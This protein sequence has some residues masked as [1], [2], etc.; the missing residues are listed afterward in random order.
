MRLT[1]KDIEKVKLELE[2]RG[3]AFGEG[4]RER[5]KVARA[6]GDLS[7]NFEYTMAKKENNQNNGRLTYLENLLMSA[8]IID[9]KL[10][11]DEVGY[12]KKVT[13]YFGDDEEDT[14]TFILVTDYNT[15]SMKNRLSDS[16]PMGA[17]VLH[18]KVGEHITKNMDDGRVLDFTI[19]SVT[20]ATDEELGFDELREKFKG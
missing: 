4:L 18:H 17:A 16:A 11:K 13:I 6:Q 5:L 12:N 2:L 20:E 8:Q 7:E 9:E 15:D 19:K 10:A 3:G 1:K 14:E